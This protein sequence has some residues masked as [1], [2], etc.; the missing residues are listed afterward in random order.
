MKVL[1]NI[2]ILAILGITNFEIK[3]QSKATI[4]IDNEVVTMAEGISFP[5]WLKAGQKIK[6]GSQVSSISV[7]EFTIDS[8][9]KNLVFS[10]VLKINTTSTVPTKKA[11]KIEALSFTTNI[12]PT[13]SISPAKFLDT[14]I[15]FWTVPPGVA[16][17]CIEVWGAGGAGTSNSSTNCCGGGGGGYAYGCFNVTAGSTYKMKV[18]AGTYGKGD[19]SIVYNLLFASGGQ[20]G[21]TT[22]VGGGGSGGG[23]GGVFNATGTNGSGSNGGSG[24]FGGLGGYLDANGC[25]NIGQKPGGGGSITKSST[26]NCGLN[27]GA[28][29]QIIIHW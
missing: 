24:A 19:S 20:A 18:G 26:S 11:W 17:I 13:T 5:F 16:K 2:L 9:S 10:Q 21:T 27:K 25:G 22:S 15:F 3:A 14:G 8:I 23:G 29:G 1:K 28:N 6:P 4:E 12:T 7:L